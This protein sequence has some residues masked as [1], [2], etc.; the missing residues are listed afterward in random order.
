MFELLK[1]ITGNGFLLTAIA[2]L[3]STVVASTYLGTR[4]RIVVQEEAVRTKALREIVATASLE[5]ELTRQ[6]ITL[7]SPLL[8]HE[9][10]TRAYQIRDAGQVVAVV[11]TAIAPDGYT[12]AIELLVG[13]SPERAI[14]GVRT[15]SHRETPGLGDKIELRK[16]DWIKSFDGTRLGQPPAERWGVVRDGGHFDQFTG[17]TITPRAVVRAVRRALEY[18]EQNHET[19]FRDADG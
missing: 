7:H 14:Y 9:A 1:A 11:F 15:V 12:G 18:A 17:A 13:L 16:S 8:G 4:E 2:L 6:P 3:V 5:Q 10:P 19:L